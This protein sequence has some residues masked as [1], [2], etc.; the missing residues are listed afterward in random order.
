MDQDHFNTPLILRVSI[1]CGPWTNPI[2][3]LFEEEHQ[4]AVDVRSE[5]LSSLRELGP[6]DLVQLTK[7]STKSSSKTSSSYHHVTGIDASTS[8]NLALYV[9]NVARTLNTTSTEK[10]YKVISGVYCC[11]NAFSRLDLR[12]KVNFP[13]QMEA[14]CVDEKGDFR[15]ASDALW[16]ETYLCSVLRAYSYADGGNGETIKR[17]I[18]CRRF[19]PITSTESE[20]KFL[21]AAVRL[22]FNGWQLGSDP[23][24]QVPNAVSNHLT[25]GLL[26][27]ITTTGRY[28]S[29]INLFEK[30]RAKDPEIASLLA[31]VLMA[32]DEEVKAVRVLHEGIEQLPMD[33]SLL[34][35]QAD[36][37]QKKGR[38]DMALHLAR[39]S[40]ISAPSE[41]STWARLADIYIAQERWDLALLTLNSCPMFTYQDKDA[42][43]IAQPDRVSLPVLPE[44]MCEEIDDAQPLAD[45]ESVHPSLRRLVAANYRGT[46]QKA[47]SLL[48]HIAKRIGWDQ[49]LRIRSQVF[50]M[51]EEYRSE[52]R[53]PSKQTNASTIALN[54]SP[55]ASIDGSENDEEERTNDAEPELSKPNHSVT[56]QTV[57]SI[58][59][60]S[61][62]AA[63][64]DHKDYTSFRHKRLCERWL[65]NL[66]MVLYEDLRIYTLWRSEVDQ[67]KRQQVKYEKTA[68]EWEIL[69]ALA[70]RLHYERE[71]IEAYQLCL[72]QRFSPKAMK[73]VMAAWQ[74]DGDLRG[75]I[76][77]EI[78]LVCWQ[79]RWYSEARYLMQ[80]RLRTG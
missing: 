64:P 14:Y 16:L 80:D 55:H 58:D 15:V 7:Q 49:L 12:V 30:L 9:N 17:I 48:T 56:T 22:F 46:F 59:E 72:G 39:R 38:Q 54:G 44:T 13:G 27:Y 78:R 1:A 18:G 70:D 43:R 63:D 61:Q 3:R 20:H 75:V 8:A 68:E 37:C 77:A 74:R 34:D 2:A 11:Y 19:N 35:A 65:D 29:G 79:Y 21:E 47:Y 40:V 23:E 66:F 31:R 10:N 36:L 33:H 53:V 5:T 60:D 62:A 24:V 69:G 4:P 51:E 42:P 6:P 76:G 57:R 67:Y 52:R 45:T 41:F 73:G 71:A 32:A 25:S 28:T 26:N 50:V